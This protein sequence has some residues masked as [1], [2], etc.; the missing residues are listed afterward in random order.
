MR[1]EMK[2]PLG[3]IADE[4]RGPSAF[5]FPSQGLVALMGGTWRRY[6]TKAFLPYFVAFA[7]EPG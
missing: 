2:K 6:P 3:H 7:G 5:A 1:L 4:Y